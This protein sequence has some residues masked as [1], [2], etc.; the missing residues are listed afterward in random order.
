MIVKY[1]IG[2][3]SIAALMAGWIGVQILWRKT[4]T[5]SAVDEDVLAGRSD[6][7]SCGCATPCATKKLSMN[8]KKE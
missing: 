1:I 5:D 4:F 7:G 8:K 2:F 6:C 3:I